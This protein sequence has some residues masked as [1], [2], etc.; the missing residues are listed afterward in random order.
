MT[1]EVEE[2]AAGPRGK[3]KVKSTTSAFRASLRTLMTKIKDADP[4]YIRCIKPNSNKV[5]TKADGSMMMEQLLKA[6]VLATVRIRQNGYC[7][8]VVHKNFVAMYTCALGP[9]AKAPNAT[10][11]EQWRAAAEA[12]IAG[13]PKVFPSLSRNGG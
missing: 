7:Y 8:R 4:H 3:G 2:A 9:K 1:K 11:A 6:G 13:L 12:I 5:P 10:T